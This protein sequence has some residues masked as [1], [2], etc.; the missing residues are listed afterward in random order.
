[1]RHPEYIHHWLQ[2]LQGD[3]KAIFTAAAKAQ[4]AA[5]FILDK[6]GLVGV[7]EDVSVTNELPVA[8]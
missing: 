7:Q 1:M 8:A 6:A 5:D 2:I 3:S 4:Q